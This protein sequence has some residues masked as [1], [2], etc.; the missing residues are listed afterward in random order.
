MGQANVYRAILAAQAQGRP[1]ALCTV[2]RAR[3]SVPRHAGA[4]LLVYADGQL[5]GTI[6]GGEMEH[7][8]IAAARQVAS[9]GQP[10]IEHYE[11]IDPK[12][13]DPGVCGGELEVFIEPI[14]PDPTVLVIGGGHVG[15]AIVHLAKWLGF[16]VVLADDRPEYCTPEWAPGA[17]EYLLA[18]IAELPRRFTFHAETYIVLPTRGM[19]LDV[20]GL[21]HL[22]DQ[23]HAYLGVI[24]SR[25]RWATA[26]NALRAHGLPEDKLRRVHSPMGLELNAETP[27]EI[28]LS[29][30]AEIVMLRRGG[31][32]E[33]MKQIQML[34]AE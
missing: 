14:K 27:E 33:P 13:G 18:P 26:V 5:V 7:R 16:R 22:L 8:V 32:G 30:L 19:P 31:T 23:P 15:K 20:E 25:R 24:G 12:Q 4:K 21:P 29:I 28:A 11:L 9:G 3:G 34:N 6:G 17:D 1:A 10:R 2:V